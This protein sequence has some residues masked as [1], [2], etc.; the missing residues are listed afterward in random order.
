[1]R[2]ILALLAAAAWAPGPSELPRFRA[3]VL[4]DTHPDLWA[5]TLADVNADGKLDVV[6]LA[7]DPSLVVWYE[8]PTWKRRVL[9]E[10]EPKGLVAIQPIDADGDG[11]T[12]FLL[13]A[14]YQHAPFNFKDGGGGVFLLKRPD[15]L[16]KP[17][18]PVRVGTIPTLHRIHLL[19]G[20]AAVCSAQDGP[21]VVLRPPAK[22]FEEPWIRETV[23]EKLRTCHNTFSV[24]WDGDGKEEIL[25][26]SRE[27]TTLWKRSASAKWEPTL[28]A[29][30]NG[31][32]SEVAVGRLPGGGRYVATIEPHHGAEFCVYV[33][34]DGAWQRKVLLV[35]KGGHTLWPADLTGTGTD[36]VLV[37]FVGA[38][39]KAPGG[40]CWYVFHP[41][42]REGEH[43]EKVLVDDKNTTGED[44]A[45]ADLNGDGRIDAVS[46]GGRHVKIYWNE[47]R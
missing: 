4:D 14:E 46:A 18:T 2:W 15:D 5:T 25:T 43:W 27:G 8:N 9:I 3:Q 45:C 30:G 16:E 34:R 19:D 22:P 28:I 29:K 40:P 17:W 42:D 10:K 23:A 7:F 39:S 20:K 11:K 13:G 1:M 37:G 35:N 44:G 24:D 26:A 31:G 32:A 33:Q 12:E 6:S 36:S 38:Y 47:G 21:T 41:T